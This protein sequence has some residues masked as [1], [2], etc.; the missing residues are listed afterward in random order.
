[1]EHP[2]DE[3]SSTSED[4]VACFEDDTE[5]FMQRKRE[6]RFSGLPPGER[7]QQQLA[8]PRFVCVVGAVD[9]ELSADSHRARRTTATYMPVF[10]WAI[11]QRHG[12]QAFPCGKIPRRKHDRLIGESLCCFAN[13]HGERG[14][15]NMRTTTQAWDTV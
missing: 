7:G 8:D 4:E 5:S 2:L 3:G 6:L 13:N 1:M 11:F 14:S 15:R 9:Q 12:R 10:V